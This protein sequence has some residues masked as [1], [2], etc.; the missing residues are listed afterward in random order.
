MT[1][2]LLTVIVV[3]A[4]GVVGKLMWLA[5]GVFPVR[6]PKEEAV[7]VFISVAFVVWAVVLLVRT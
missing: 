6:T 2:F 4:L 3:M 1:W 7:D 5:S